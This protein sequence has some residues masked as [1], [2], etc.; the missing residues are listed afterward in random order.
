MHR[1]LPPHPFIEKNKAAVTAL[2]LA[3]CPA[4]GSGAIGN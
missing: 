3:Y 4:Y 2:H 1:P